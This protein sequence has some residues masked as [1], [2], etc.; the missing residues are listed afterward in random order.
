MGSLLYNIFLLFVIVLLGTMAYGGI[1]GAPWVPTNKKDRQRYAEKLPIKDGMTI[2]DLGCGDG[3]VLFALV[4]RHPS[5][6]AI[7]Y[8]VALLPLIIG[9]IRKA[10]SRGKYANVSLRRANFYRTDFSDA[11]AVFVFLMPKCYPQTFRRL[12]EQL[13]DDALAF[14]EC[15]PFSEIE[16][17]ATIEAEDGPSVYIYRGKQFKK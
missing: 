16:A 9:W 15:W 13:K 11:D 3:S 6:R 4:D 14:I 12:G 17:E 2:Y 5:I 8:D 10:L 7:G 1:I